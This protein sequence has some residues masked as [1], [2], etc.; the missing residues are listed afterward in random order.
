MQLERIRLD[1]GKNI[2]ATGMVTSRAR[3]SEEAVKNLCYETF[4][5]TLLNK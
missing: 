5:K 1:I 4:L 3:W 2:L